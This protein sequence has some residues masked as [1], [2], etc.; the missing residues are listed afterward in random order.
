MRFFNLPK[1]TAKQIA[2]ALTSINDPAELRKIKSNLFDFYLKSFKWSQ[3]TSADTFEADTKD[4]AFGIIPTHLNPQLVV[5]D[6]D[7]AEAC[8]RIDANLGETLTHQTLRGKH[9][10]FYAP[11]DLNTADLKPN[12][13]LKIDIF[14]HHDTRIIY[15]GANTN[16][17]KRIDN[18]FIEPRELTWDEF[19]WLQKISE[20]GEGQSAATRTA[21]RG[22]I[23]ENRKYLADRAYN[24]M[25]MQGEKDV[26][27]GEINMELG[28]DLTQYG[29]G[30]GRNDFLIRTLYKYGTSGFFKSQ[31]DLKEFIL[32]INTKM[33]APLS[34]DELNKT[35]LRDANFAKFVWEKEGIELSKHK[36]IKP[37][38]KIPPYFLAHNLFTDKATA[39]YLLIDTRNDRLEVFVLN[40]VPLIH[41]YANGEKYSDLHELHFSSHYAEKDKDK[42]KSKKQLVWD[43]D[44]AKIPCAKLIENEGFSPTIFSWD[45][46]ILEIHTGFYTYNP[47]IQQ[48]IDTPNLKTQ[49]EIWE[50]VSKTR[51][52][53]VYCRNLLNEFEIFL[54]FHGDIAEILRQK[55]Y[56]R[57]MCVFKDIYGSTGKDSVMTTHLATMFLGHS[58]E[59]DA[60][61]PA[62]LLYSSL[63]NNGITK[64]SCGEFLQ[65]QFTEYGDSPLFILNEDGDLKRV[66]EPIFNNKLKTIVK[67]PTIRIRKM[68]QNGEGNRKNR[69]YVVR[70]TNSQDYALPVGDTN[71]RIYMSVVKQDI[72][73]AEWAEMFPDDD[74]TMTADEIDAWLDFYLYY[75]FAAQGYKGLHILP[76]EPE[77]DNKTEQIESLL[78]NRAILKSQ[79]FAATRILEYFFDTNLKAVN[80]KRCLDIPSPL[81]NSSQETNTLSCLYMLAQALLS[82]SSYCKEE[83]GYVRRSDLAQ[84]FRVE[85]DLKPGTMWNASVKRLLGA[86]NS[87]D[88]LKISYTA[89]P[90]EV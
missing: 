36:L 77:S 10:Y 27:L 52:F 5:V 79:D 7:D 46:D 41:K 71:T 13:T 78:E 48:K 83:F 21:P 38:N 50:N 30:S 89:A 72:S 16:Y 33:P 80:I 17:Y 32:F 1:T 57:T 59:R 88:R 20:M 85:I 87:A 3:M 45:E 56:I 23:F 90:D 75:D 60:G 11:D 43:L 34:I 31:N 14:T 76:K 49:D 24:L 66:Q 42:E 35:I 9:Y 81:S 86:S 12:H 18:D 37:G 69:L 84:I 28:I 74:Y 61:K 67:S 62:N 25:R 47:K 58:G 4:V 68:F 40:S 19:Y 65:S 29:E 70:Y 55:T 6:G 53:Q 26:S 39:Q 15:E 44:P 82:K 51:Q 64:Q 54:K 73:R 2:D 8:A 63:Y 22:K